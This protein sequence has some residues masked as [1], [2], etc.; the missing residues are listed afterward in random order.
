MAFKSFSRNILGVNLLRFINRFLKSASLYPIKAFQKSERLFGAKG[1]GF[2]KPVDGFYLQ[3]DSPVVLG[4]EFCGSSLYFSRFENYELTFFS[5]E[6]RILPEPKV[7]F[8][9]SDSIP[10]NPEQNKS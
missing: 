6:R 8:S 2:Q 1:G 7:L 4:E 3:G 5:R 9:L 10:L